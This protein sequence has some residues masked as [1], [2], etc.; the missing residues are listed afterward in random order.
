MNIEE[1]TQ[2]VQEIKEVKQ[3][4]GIGWVV[5][6]ILTSIALIAFWKFF[7][8][9]MEK[10]AEEISDK[11]L[12]SF[13]SQLNKDYFKFT[14][15]HQKQVDAI[16]ETFQKFQLMTLAIKH[17]REGENFK[18]PVKPHDEISSL[19]NQRHDFKNTY[20]QNRLLFS[21]ELCHKIDTLIPIVDN[22][23][24]TYTSG[25]LPEPSDE[26]KEF[27][28]DVNKGSYIAGVW[29]FGAF[30]ETIKKLEHVSREIEIEFRKIYCTDEK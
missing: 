18:L 30:D 4:Y 19:I 14:T 26:D 5:L 10:I 16:H 8:R 24:E 15:K 12:K 27:Y 11:N 13:Q 1:L 2:I 21:I 29:S 9:R 6:I 7:I 3:L 17:M 23:I 20:N 22:F 25:I 28:A